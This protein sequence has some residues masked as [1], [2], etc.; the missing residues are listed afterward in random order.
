MQRRT[1][2]AAAFALLAAVTTTDALA[3]TSLRVFS[4]GANQRPDLMRKL[5]DQY[6][7]ANPGRRSTST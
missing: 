5:F 1:T 2:L 6:Q 4:G 3:Q 7:A